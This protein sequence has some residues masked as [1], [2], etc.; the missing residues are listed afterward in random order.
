M[1]F[2]IIHLQEPLAADSV[3]DAYCVMHHTSCDSYNTL[4]CIKVNTYFENIYAK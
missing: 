2:T 4:F 1:S 3:D